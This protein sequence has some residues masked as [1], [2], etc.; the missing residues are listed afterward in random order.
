MT[1]NYDKPVK[2]LIA[3]LDKTGHVT[4]N[5][6][7]KKS[8]TLH[9]N[10]GVNISHQGILNIWKTRPASAHFD[11]DRHGDVAQYVRVH[12][13]AWAVANTRGNQETI[14]IEMTNSTGSPHWEVSDTTWMSAC[15]L[16]GWL[17]A[18]V[19]GERPTEHNLFYHHHWYNTD[20]AG[21][22]MDKIYHKV[23]KETQDWYI[24][25]KHRMSH[26]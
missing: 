11:V 3:G 20:C 6:Y 24:H 10:G 13:Y 2:N 26:H 14:S 22:Y 12:E 16:A 5:K 15:R 9:H 23:L 7:K 25:F 19:V 18:H 8:V 4:H 1:I 17:F 21:P